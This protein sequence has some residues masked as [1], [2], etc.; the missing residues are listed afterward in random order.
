MRP[1]R[2]TSGPGSLSIP[3]EA[4]PAPAPPV[5]RGSRT[6]FRSQPQIRTPTTAG[7]R[8]RCPAHP[9]QRVGEQRD[10][11]PASPSHPC[12]RGQAPPSEW[13]GQLW[14]LGVGAAGRPSRPAGLPRGRRGGSAVPSP[15]PPAVPGGPSLCAGFLNVLFFK[16][17]NICSPPSSRGRRSW[18]AADPAARRRSRL[19]PLPGLAKS[20]AGRRP[21]QEKPRPP[22]TRLPPPASRS[23]RG[24]TGAGRGGGRAETRGPGGPRGGGRGAPLP[25][26]CTGEATQ[27]R[28]RGSQ[29]A[30]GR[31]GH[32]H[33]LGQLG[34]ERSGPVGH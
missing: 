6:P 22:S 12:R 18:V 34:L 2:G 15:C 9:L 33:Q 14:E 32:D 21:A 5:P 13:P 7:P 11:C 24:L 1:Q 3:D 29:L 16:Y 28:G 19:L 4:G 30:V 20:H 8:Y 17:E 26:L 27:P 31:L 23:P 10:A 25:L